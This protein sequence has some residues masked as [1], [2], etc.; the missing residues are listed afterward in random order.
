MR[1]RSSYSVAFL[2]TSMVMMV[3]GVVVM[4]QDMPGTGALLFA[5]AVVFRLLWWWSC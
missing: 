4:V 5:G 2:A 1:S 3:G